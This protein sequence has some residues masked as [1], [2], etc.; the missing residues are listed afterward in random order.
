MIHRRDCLTTLLAVG[1]SGS[2]RVSAQALAGPPISFIVPQPA[3]NPTDVLA[4]RL[5]MVAQ[6]ELGQPLIMDN[7]PGAG[8]SLGV[9]KMLSAPTG[10]PI[11]L[12]ASQTESILTPLSV[13]AARYS[14]DK[15]RPVLLITRGPYV[16]LGRADLPARNLG[17]LIQL[18]RQRASRPLAY[19]HIGNGSMIHLLGER[20]ARK[21]GFALTQVPY[22]GVPPVLQDLIGGQIDITFVPQSAVRDLASSG[23]VKVLGTTGSAASDRLPEALPLSKLDPSLSDFVHGTWGAVFVSRS[24][25]DEEVRRLHKALTVAC[26]EPQFQAQTAASG[27]EP[28][29]P[30]TLQELER[31]FDD[32][33]RLYQAMARE[34]GIQP[35]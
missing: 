9:N 18:A 21:A 6:R 14:S 13:K 5:Q 35:E 7:L 34:I 30:M 26:H 12:I 2:V 16:L 8:G 17:E 1:L 28:A 19:G 4:R 33:T 11:L 10:T 3:G 31:F 22:K 15:L 23:K 29:P 25:P 20:L 27:S 24:L 32:E